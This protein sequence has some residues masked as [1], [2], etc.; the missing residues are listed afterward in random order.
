MRILLVILV[1]ALIVASVWLILAARRAATADRWRVEIDTAG[2]GA[3][4]VAVVSGRGARR[5]V[6]SLPPAAEGVDLTSDLRIAREDA[7]A[8]AAEL[9]GRR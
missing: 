7:Q 4:E 9:N 8:L 2:D 5:L 1:V 6:R 3:L